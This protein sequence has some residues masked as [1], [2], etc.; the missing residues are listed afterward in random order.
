MKRIFTMLAIML[1][2]SMANAS[3]LYWQLDSDYSGEYTNARIVSSGD[4]VNA[5]EVLGL[6]YNT[7]KKEYE[8]T[9]ADT[10]LKS[11]AAYLI[12]VNDINPD[13]S[14]YIEY[15]NNDGANWTTYGGDKGVSGADLIS[16]AS[17][18]EVASAKDISV[19]P[20]VW[21]VTSTSSAIPEPTSGLLLLF[22]AAMLGLKRKN[23]SRA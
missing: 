6:T 20:A 4:T 23:S 12:D 18:A 17:A 1:V 21:H 2:A 14:Y 8:V 9:S 11:G 19:T 15:S 7:E 5:I 16:Y 13:Y 10:N 3:Y 22:G